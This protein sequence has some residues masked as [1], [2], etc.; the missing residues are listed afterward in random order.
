M[1]TM[2]MLVKQRW[3]AGTFHMFHGPEMYG[4]YKIDRIHT[5]LFIYIYKYRSKGQPSLGCFNF[6]ASGHVGYEDDLQL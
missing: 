4:K 2:E 3:L 1:I 6:V 5:Y